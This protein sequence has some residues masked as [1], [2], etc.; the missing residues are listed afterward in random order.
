[1][2]NAETPRKSFWQFPITLKFVVAW[3]FLLSLSGFWSVIDG[4]IS[5]RAIKIIPFIAGVVYFYLAIGL[6]DGD[7]AARILTSVLVSIGSLLRV[8]FLVSITFSLHLGFDLLGLP[9]TDSQKIVLLIL[10]LA[11]NAIILYILLR[12]STKVLF[13]SQSTSISEP[14]PQETT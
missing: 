8:I 4:L 7:N 14:T 9:L 10:N 5:V 12:P 1:M 6:A 11:F 13:L 2:I 3:I